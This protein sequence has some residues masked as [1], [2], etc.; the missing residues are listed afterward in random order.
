MQQIHNQ[1]LDKFLKYESPSIDYKVFK[2]SELPS[3]NRHIRVVL[4]CKDVVYKIHQRTY[5]SFQ[6]KLV[7]NLRPFFERYPDALEFSDRYE[8]DICWTAWQRVEGVNLSHDMN[9]DE[10]NSFLDHV[11]IWLKTQQDVSEQLGIH[12][13][14]MWCHNDITPWNTIKGNDKLTLVDWDDF[15]L[16]EL[17]VVKHDIIHANV[18][19]AR[20]TGRDVNTVYRKFGKL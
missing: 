11:V 3:D 5:Q 2:F 19:F 6:Q 16:R 14:C 15:G 4:V 12:S 17:G 10:W 1:L 13:S 8:K 7:S 18:E 20:M 9:T